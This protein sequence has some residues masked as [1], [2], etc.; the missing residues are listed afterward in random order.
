MAETD[1][2]KNFDADYINNISTKQKQI[3][4]MTP[5]HFKIL[6]LVLDGAKPSIIAKKLSMS[7]S[8]ASIIIRS[9]LF[10]HQLAIRRSQ[11]EEK[12]ADRAA[13]AVDEVKE[14]LQKSAISAANKLI[15]GIDSDNETI[16]LKSATEILDRTGYPKEQKMTGSETN[17]Q[18]IINATDF[19]VLKESLILDSSAHLNNNIDEV[20]TDLLDGAESKSGS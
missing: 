15:F 1:Y 19:S 18:I 5:R 12:Q 17:T 9:Q 14:A 4:L 6:D 2:T 10:Q 3:Q 7:Y 8:Q 16:A 20:G 11:Y 13:I